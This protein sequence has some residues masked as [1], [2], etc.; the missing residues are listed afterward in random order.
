MDDLRKM[1][2]GTEIIFMSHGNS[3][4]DKGAEIYGFE[5]S[6]YVLYRLIGEPRRPAK[7]AKADKKGVAKARLWID[8]GAIR[9]NEASPAGPVRDLCKGAGR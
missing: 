4:L 1:Y 2:P 6:D 8:P 7:K 5:K 3:Q 9:G